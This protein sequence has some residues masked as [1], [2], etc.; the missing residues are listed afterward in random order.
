[1]SDRSPTPE[2]IARNLEKLAT[3]LS[4]KGLISKDSYSAI[5]SARSEASKKRT[6]IWEYRIRREKSLSFKE[7]EC[8]G[9]KMRI[10]VFCVIA[11]DENFEIKKQNVEIRVWSLEKDL[12]YREG[13]DAKELE[14]QFAD[15]NWKRVIMRFHF[16]LKPDEANEPI[17]HFHVGGRIYDDADKFCWISERIETPRFPYQ[18]MDLI[19][20]TEFILRNFF[21]A[22]EKAQKLLIDPAWRKLVIGSQDCFVKGY[23]KNL[24]NHGFSE[25]ATLLDNLCN[26]QKISNIT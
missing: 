23:Y 8:N 11:Y 2:I 10:D 15:K 18:P 1:M 6:P 20:V 14:Q 17:F 25:D 19:L 12:S 22:D 5:L 4:S 16:D 21:Q 3:Y 24:V 13:L 9:Q 7:C 26:N